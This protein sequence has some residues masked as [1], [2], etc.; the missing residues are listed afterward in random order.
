MGAGGVPGKEFLTNSMIEPTLRIS[1]DTN[2]ILPT[3]LNEKNIGVYP[4]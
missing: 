1:N 2:C 3:N 4:T